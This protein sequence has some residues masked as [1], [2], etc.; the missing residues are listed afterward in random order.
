MIKQ[1]LKI[2]FLKQ[3][4]VKDAAQGKIAEYF[5]KVYLLYRAK[6]AIAGVCAVLGV[7]LIILFICIE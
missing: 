3:K 7:R 2:D 5:P 1:E 4:L 6:L